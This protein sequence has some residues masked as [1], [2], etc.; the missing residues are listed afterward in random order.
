MALD[1]RRLPSPVGRRPA[2]GAGIGAAAVAFCAIA[3]ALVPRSA[4]A[5]AA[6]EPAPSGGGIRG[7][8]ARLEAETVRILGAEVT[9]PMKAP[10]AAR[11]T[12]LWACVSIAQWQRQVV[13]EAPSLAR[14]VE[15]AGRRAEVLWS[16]ARILDPHASPIAQMASV[17]AMQR[18]LVRVLAQLGV[19]S[20]P[21][22]PTVTAPSRSTD[23]P[24]PISATTS[25][26]AHAAPAPV[27]PTAVR[28]VAHPTVPPTAPATPVLSP[29]Q[30][31]AYAAALEQ[32]AARIL[33]S[34]LEGPVLAAVARDKA[35]RSSAS[36][37]SAW[38]D[39]LVRSHPGLARTTAVLVR[40]SEVLR[41]SLGVRDAYASAA[42]Q[43]AAVRGLERGVARLLAQ[44]GR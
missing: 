32:E 35:L 23:R 28:A 22:P 41:E 40:R 13:A 11:G 3:G 18:G 16:E 25:P 39:A 30:L 44:Y 17:H 14:S 27:P 26:A 31:A 21:P 2:R 5:E 8:Q 10:L 33:A 29:V 36:T 6:A 15:V 7:F 37:V 12:S 42:T 24:E 43:Q 4:W 9:G 20:T 38:R 34:E 1:P 19:R